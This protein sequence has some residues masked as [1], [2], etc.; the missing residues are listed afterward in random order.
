MSESKTDRPHDTRLK[1]LFGNKEAFISLLRDCIKA[2]W[3]DDLDEESLKRSNKSFVLQDFK[4]QEADVV[5]E[6]ALKNG[7]DKVIFYILLE[8]QRKVDHRMSYRLL[9][10][11]VEVLRDYYNQSDV[12]ERKRKDFRFPAVYP[13]VFYNVAPVSKAA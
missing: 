6:A 7:G 12:K 3:V 2:D 9:L 4:K 1:E 11:I 8:N 13:I 5:Y 10:Y